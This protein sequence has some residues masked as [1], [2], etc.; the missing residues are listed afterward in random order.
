MQ[1]ARVRGAHVVLRVP[2]AN[3]RQPGERLP[4]G[5]QGATR[6]A[7]LR[8][9]WQ[10]IQERVRDADAQLRVSPTGDSR[11]RDRGV[12]RIGV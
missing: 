1:Q 6:V 10:H 8:I 12:R 5:L 2:G 7:D 4:P 3:V 11:I 9:G